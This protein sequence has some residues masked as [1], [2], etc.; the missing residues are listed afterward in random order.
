MNLEQISR[1]DKFTGSFTIVTPPLKCITCR[2]CK[3]LFLHSY[4]IFRTDRKQGNKQEKKKKTT[5]R[6]RKDTGGGG[7]PVEDHED[8]SNN[9]INICNSGETKPTKL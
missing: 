5:G 3:N 2:E 8:V 1:I 6:Q 9:I 4:F 7:N